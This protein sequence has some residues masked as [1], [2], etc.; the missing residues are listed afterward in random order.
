MDIKDIL[1]FVLSP[2][3]LAAIGGSAAYYFWGRK[4]QGYKPW[5]YTGGGMLAG[6]ALGHL[7][8][9]FLH[10]GQVPAQLTPPPRPT[11]GV[12]P[13]LTPEQQAE[14]NAMIG[15]QQQARAYV[16]LD[17]PARALPPAQA[18]YTD[19]GVPTA[20]ATAPT[21]D[22][23]VAT[24]SSIAPDDVQLLHGAGSYGESIGGNGLGSYSGNDHDEEVDALMKEIAKSAKRGRN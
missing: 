21:G 9:G 13:G 24:E 6:Y 16:D 17:A 23:I 14:L 22:K 3:L 12:R 8:Q 15:Q 10:P 1:Q 2:K 18:V 4:E 7:A 5:L 19:V 20:G 11:N